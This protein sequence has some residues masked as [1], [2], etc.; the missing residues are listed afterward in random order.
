MTTSDAKRF[1]L[2]NSERKKWAMCGWTF[3]GREYQQRDDDNHT[4]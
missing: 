2:I 4:I 3:V 1:Y